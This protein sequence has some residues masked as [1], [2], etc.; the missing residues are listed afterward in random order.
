MTGTRNTL[1]ILFL[2]I[3]ICLLFLLN[4]LAGSVA[5]P[6][7]EVFS[8]LA[9]NPTDN[10][11]WKYI[12]LES[13]FPQAITAAI[14]GSSLAVTGLLLQTAFRNPLAGPGIFGVNTGAALGVAIVMMSFGGTLAAGDISLNGFVAVIAAALLGAFAV[15][16]LI[17]GVSNVV[18]S[19]T[20]LLIVG[21]M[22]GYLASSAISLLNFFST[23]EGV[24]AYTI[25]GMGTFSSV[26][27]EAILPFS[28]CCLSGLAGSL[29]LIKP[30]NSLL[31]GEN[32]ARNLGIS[33]MK[34]RTILLLITGWLTAIVTAYCGPVGFIGLAV[35]HIARLLFKTDNHL[36]LLPATIIA[37]AVIALL[38]N[39]ICV[40]PGNNGIIPL[41]A[42]TPLIGAPVIIYIIIKNPSRN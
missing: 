30:L 32:Y 34:I 19:N 6:F 15:I 13:R 8:I 42:V 41:S 38:C 26:S 17:L 39:L 24:H 10:T 35:P 20:M 33:P 7:S 18:R 1:K 12:V 2:S 25:W 29:M 22:I 21:I 14:A 36:T 3:L 11:A 9:G 27:R 23:S 5:I 28:I 16:A 37:G 4:L 40:I 31:L